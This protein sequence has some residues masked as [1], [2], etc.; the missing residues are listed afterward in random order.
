MQEIREYCL[1]KPQ[2]TESFPFDD[3]ALVFKVYDKMYALLSLSNQRINL[4]VHP[5][6]IE[7]L[8]EQYPEVSPGFH[9]N[10]KHWN[11]IDLTGRL[12]LDLVYKWIDESYRLVVLNMN[13]AKQKEL[14]GE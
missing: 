3:N 6:N 7:Q 11:T 8:R 9:M 1:S 5:E 4:K 14:L 2:T 10:K 12:P 13:K